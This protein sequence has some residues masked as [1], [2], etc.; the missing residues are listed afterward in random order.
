MLSFNIQNAHKFIGG[1]Q[2]LLAKLQGPSEGG[3]GPPRDAKVTKKKT[4]KVNPV[5]NY[6]FRPSKFI[7][8]QTEP[9]AGYDAMG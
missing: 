1:A 2:S 6:Q 3:E 4:F 8:R 7:K 5:D 9:L